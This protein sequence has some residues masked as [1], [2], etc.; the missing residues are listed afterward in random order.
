[1]TDYRF[2]VVAKMKVAHK[3]ILFTHGIIHREHL[4]ATAY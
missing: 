4:A 2:G 1:M 3:E